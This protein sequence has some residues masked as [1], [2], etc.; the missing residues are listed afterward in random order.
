M[1]ACRHVVIY[2]CKYVG[3][4]VCPNV[5][6]GEELIGLSKITCFMFRDDSDDGTVTLQTTVPDTITSWVASAFAMSSD[7]GMGIAPTTAMVGA[8]T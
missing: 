5:I 3:T 6:I 1:A 7:V 4:S 8:P 2:I